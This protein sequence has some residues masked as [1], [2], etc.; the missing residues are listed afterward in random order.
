MNR[1]AAAAGRGQANKQLTESPNPVD[2]IIEILIYG[3]VVHGD[4]QI[5]RPTS[6]KVRDGLKDALRATLRGAAR[7]RH[8][9]CAGADVAGEAAPQK[10]A[11]P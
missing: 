5:G 10:R 8:G 2:A 7:A 3:L 1:R 4:E 6:E 11:Y 9:R